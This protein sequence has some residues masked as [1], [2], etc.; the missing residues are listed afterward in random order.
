MASQWEQK[1]WLMFYKRDFILV[2][3]NNILCLRFSTPD[4]FWGAVGVQQDGHGNGGGHDHRSAAVA[5]GHGGAVP[6]AG[7]EVEAAAGS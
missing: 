6:A 5:G 3:Q 1:L 7:Q 4:P 2:L